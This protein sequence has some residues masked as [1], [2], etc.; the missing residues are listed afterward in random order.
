MEQTKEVQVAAVM[1]APRYECVAARS[2]IERS[3]N[4][5][6]IP[7]TISGGVFYGQCMQEMFEGLVG[8]I[9]YVLTV[10]F[11]S[12]FLPKH[13]M[14]LLSIIAQEDHIDAIAAIQPMRGKGRI[15]ASRQKDN[16]IDWDGR[17]LKADTLHFGLTVI[18]VAKLAEVPKPWFFAQPDPN[19]SWNDGRCDSDTWFWRQW[20]KAGFSAYLDPGCRLG[21]LEE[22]VSVFDSKLQLQHYYPKQW[23]DLAE[24]TC[25]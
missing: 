3:L 20:E 22:M 13:V 9:D 1:T 11:D 17:P 23:S 6:G 4:Q 7:L 5:A 10:D 8:K 21:H 15:L 16:Q 2:R 19:G 25:E 18:D 12:M 24:E 14:R